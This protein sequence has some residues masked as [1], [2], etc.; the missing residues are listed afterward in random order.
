MPETGGSWVQEEFAAHW[1]QE[2]FTAHVEN[3][4][5]RC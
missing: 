2:E 3:S 4:I 1:V 5:E